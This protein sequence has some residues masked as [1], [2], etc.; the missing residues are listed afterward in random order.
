MAVASSSRR[1]SRVPVPELATQ[2]EVDV[3]KLKAELPDDD[4]YVVVHRLCDCFTPEVPYVKASHMFYQSPW[5]A[6][7][8]YASE[9]NLSSQAVKSIIDSV[10]GTN[11]GAKSL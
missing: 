2:D 8:G 7:G 11:F 1:E 4:S 6:I 5:D 9:Y 3:G 10:I